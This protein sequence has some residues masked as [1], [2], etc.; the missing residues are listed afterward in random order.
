M[1]KPDPIQIDPKTFLRTDCSLPA[2][3][4]IVL[5]IQEIIQSDDPDIEDVVAQIK[6]DPGIV[7]QI[8]KIVNSAYFGLP[9]EISDVKFAVAYLGLN[10]IFRII[11]PISVVKS[12]SIK[13]KKELNRFWFH[14]YFSAIIS[15][16][17]G[18]KY[19]PHLPFED[20]WS[21]AILHDIGKLVFLKFF[22]DQYKVLSGHCR[23]EGCLFSQAEEFYSLPTSAYMGS[24]LCDRWNLPYSIKEACRSHGLAGLTEPGEKNKAVS[25]NRIITLGNLAAILSENELNPDTKDVLIKAMKA[26]LDLDEQEFLALMGMIY[27]LKIEAEE[28]K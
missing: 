21:A 24:L 1:E 10:E 6:K 23:R 25:F 9:R 13:N 3:S 27:E 8:L 19:E 2:L 26:S 12:L 5:K 15:K 11:L 7:A 22:P 4:S 28:F 20:L 18:K 14:S 16:H 17:I